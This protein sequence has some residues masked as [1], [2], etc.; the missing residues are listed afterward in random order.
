[1]DQEL[2]FTQLQYIISLLKL[3]TKE[4]EEHDP[5]EV[6]SPEEFSKVL[7]TFFDGKVSAADIDKLMTAAQTELD[8]TEST[9]I[10]FTK[11]FFE[12][13]ISNTY[14]LAKCMY[15]K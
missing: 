4:N 1:M 9:D 12:V 15:Y 3:L 5:P 10:E 8:D 7:N 2:F 6:F 13:K 14:R 11:L